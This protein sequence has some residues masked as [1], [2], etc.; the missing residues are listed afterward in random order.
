MIPLALLHP[1]PLDPAFWDPVRAILA[2]DRPVLAPAFP[3]FGGTPVR[4]GVSIEGFADDVAGL[5][6]REAPEGR[7]V[8]CGLSMGGYAALALAERHP[9]RVA[10]LV[11]ADTRAE[12]DD[13]AG[14]AGRD[15][16]IVTVRSAGLDA[17]LDGF[18][19]RLLAPGADED[20]LARVRRIADRQP[21]EAVVAAL[22]ALRERP[23]RRAMLG[24]VR[25]PTLV[26]VGAEDVLTPPPFA[27][28][29]AAGIP[30]ARLE[31]MPGAGPLT[32][33]EDPETFASLVRRFVRGTDIDPPL[34]D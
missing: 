25:V 5:I 23:D 16:A 6:A 4:H 28:T 30:G 14:R 8:V 26:V 9:D 18:V 19:P 34:P 22:G 12:A 24:G 7:A 10:A 2:V 31:V 17:F 32:A 21:G 1:F 13:D 3:G 11:L 33:L 27:E 15:Q 29:L 20:T